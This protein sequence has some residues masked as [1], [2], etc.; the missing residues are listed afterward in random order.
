VGDPDGW[1][2]VDM[3]AL[4]Q[5]P[6]IKK[7]LAPFGNPMDI[8]FNGGWKESLR[9]A[10]WAATGLIVDGK[11]VRLHLAT[12]GTLRASG[13]GG[14]TLPTPGASI[15]PNLRVPRELAAASLWRDLGKFYSGREAFFPHRTSGGIL[16]ENFMEIFFTGR[17]LTDDVFSKFHPQVRLVVARQEYDANVGTP[18]EQYRQLF[19]S[20]PERA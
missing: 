16:A 17:D 12:D 5:A 3:A 8:L 7:E 15:L 10:R 9:A 2:F 4:K 14:F 11:K 20:P 1:I 13:A 19:A 18:E 6:P